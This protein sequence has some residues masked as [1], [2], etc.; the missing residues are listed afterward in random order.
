MTGYEGYGYTRSV[1][2]LQVADGEIA[3]ILLEKK[4][5]SGKASVY[6]T[7]EYLDTTTPP[8]PGEAIEAAAAR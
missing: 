1:L 4:R 8:S 7:G 2:K 3:D 6:G 5:P